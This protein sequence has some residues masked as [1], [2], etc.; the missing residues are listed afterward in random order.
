[1]GLY[2]GSMKRSAEDF[3]TV[4]AA[5]IESHLPHGDSLLRNETENKTWIKY[6][7]TVHGLPLQDRV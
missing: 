6:S 4:T 1:M 3:R 7:E 2:C 5:V